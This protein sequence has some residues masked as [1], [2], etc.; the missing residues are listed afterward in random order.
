MIQGETEIFFLEY[1]CRWNKSAGVL[2]EEWFS[3]PNLDPSNRLA[4]WTP[5]FS[6][7]P[8]DSFPSHTGL[9]SQ[10]FLHLFPHMFLGHLELYLFGK[11]CGSRYRYPHSVLNIDWVWGEIQRS[12]KTGPRK[13]IKMFDLVNNC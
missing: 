7:L 6:H 8:N 3:D 2:V 4:S 1:L 12:A 10:G 9:L 5:I 11:I 13:H